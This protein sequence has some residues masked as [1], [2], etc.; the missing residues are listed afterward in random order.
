MNILLVSRKNGAGLSRDIAIFTRVLS[1]LGHDVR[2]VAFDEQPPQHPVADVAIFLEL[3]HIG[4]SRCAWR[5]ILVPNEEWWPTEW[6][7]WLPTID[8][9][10]CKSRHA[11]DAFKKAG[12]RT[13]YIGMTSLDRS[14]DDY[15]KPDDVDEQ[16]C[17]HAP[18]SSR[19]KGTQAVL[20]AWHAHPEWPLLICVSRKLEYS[21]DC[22]D[23]VCIVDE[24]LTEERFGALQQHAMLVVHP[25]EAEGYGHAIAEA[26]SAGRRVLT[27]DAPPMNELISSPGC[28]YLAA[29]ETA[30]PFRASELYRVSRETLAVAI[31]EA[32]QDERDTGKMARDLWEGRDVFFRRKI[33]ELFG[34]TKTK[35]SS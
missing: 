28:G 30:I 7:V 23:N 10:L 27:T 21:G 29:W 2:Y 17:L 11:L 1:T 19:L 3:F 18:G 24:Y 26:M 25:S 9:V 15:S 13:Q 20:N 5:T 14:L 8:L 33:S 31:E 4:W 22:P 34:S 35:K 12:A 16:Y 6:H 32:L